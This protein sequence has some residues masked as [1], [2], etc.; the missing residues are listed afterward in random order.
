M[1]WS[2]VSRGPVHVVEVPGSHTSILLQPG[3][4]RLAEELKAALDRA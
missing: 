2:A 3:V 1:G 4:Q